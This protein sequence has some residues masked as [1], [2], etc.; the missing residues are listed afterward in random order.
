MPALI[1]VA[2]Q[3]LQALGAQLIDLVAGAIIHSLVFANRDIHVPPTAHG[4][5]EVEQAEQADHEEEA[6]ADPALADLAQAG[7]EIAEKPTHEGNRMFRL[8]G[9]THQ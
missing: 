7:D 5:A 2:R 9:S 3:L 4:L 1:E 6:F 8:T